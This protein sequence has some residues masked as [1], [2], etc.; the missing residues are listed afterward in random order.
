[1]E[2]KNIKEVEEEKRRLLDSQEFCRNK[3]EKI[4]K[5]PAKLTHPEKREFMKP[6]KTNREDR[7]NFVKFWANYVRTHSDKEWSRQQNVLIDSQIEHAH[8]LVRKTVDS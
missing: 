5:T 4:G 7:I 3:K 2:K 8:N 6:G 1:M